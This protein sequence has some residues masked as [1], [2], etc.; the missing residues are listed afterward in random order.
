[1]GKRRAA[2]VVSPLSNAKN[3]ADG[4]FVT[5][6]PDDPPETPMPLPNF[7]QSLRDFGDFLLWLFT[8]RCCR[9]SKI[10]NRSSR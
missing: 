5:I 6:W 10:V 4:Q 1:L 8:G 3:R 7:W 9:L 2:S